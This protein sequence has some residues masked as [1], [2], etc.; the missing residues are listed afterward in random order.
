MVLAN[1]KRPLHKGAQM[2]I[3]DLMTVSNDMFVAA[4]AEFPQINKRIVHPYHVGMGACVEIKCDGITSLSH[5]KLGAEMNF[6]DMNQAYRNGMFGDNPKIWGDMEWSLLLDYLSGGI[7]H[8]QDDW[9]ALTW[10]PQVWNTETMTESKATTSRKGAH[11]RARGTREK[12][13]RVLDAHVLHRAVHGGRRP[14]DHHGI[15]GL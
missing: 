13:R 15:H 9:E 7:A 12:R 3:M 6:L 1:S 4:M 10:Q 8:S 2:S 5:D 11:P 14:V